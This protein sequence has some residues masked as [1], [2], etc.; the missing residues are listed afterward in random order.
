MRA[1]E[2]CK[3]HLFISLGIKE[4]CDSEKGGGGGG[5]KNMSVTTNVQ[6]TLLVSN[7]LLI[8]EIFQ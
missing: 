8:T 7:K 6:C 3:M 1:S 2:T 5:G 4:K